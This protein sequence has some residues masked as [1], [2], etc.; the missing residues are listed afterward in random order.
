MVQTAGPGYDDR[1]ACIKCGRRASFHSPL[2]ALCPTDA[3]L[4]ATRHGWIPTQLGAPAPC[5]VE[6]GREGT[7][8]K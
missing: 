3:L 7:R 5:E 6:E 8:P 1:P 2:G 4:A